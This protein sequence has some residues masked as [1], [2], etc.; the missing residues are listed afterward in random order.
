[1]QR[2][3]LLRGQSLKRVVSARMAEMVAGFYPTAHA[4]Q[5]EFASDYLC[6]AFTLDDVGDETAAGLRP[7]HL[8]ELFERL[9]ELFYGGR[10]RADAS[11]LEFA[12]ED[13]MLR[14]A[15]FATNESVRAFHEANRAYFGGML[16]E[17]NNRAAKSMPDE[18]AYLTHRPA[19]GAVPPF[20]ELIHPLEGISMSQRVREDANIAELTRL[21]RSAREPQRPPQS[22]VAALAPP[23]PPA[24]P[25]RLP[26]PPAR[27]GSDAEAGK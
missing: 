13:L 1:M 26:P 16:W 24:A 8:V 21:A 7:A 22:S 4:T 6:W 19:A 20:F 23:V 12:F 27:G 5:L 9:E 11:A 25:R 15:G 2:L 14:F 17:A 18:D 10:A 3:K